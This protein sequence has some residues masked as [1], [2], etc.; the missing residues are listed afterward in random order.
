MVSQSS[1]LAK[2]MVLR[3]DCFGLA[4]QAEDEVGVDDEAEVVAVLD[5]VAGALDGGALLDVLEDLRVAGL[6]ADDEQAAAGSFMAL[7]VSR[8]VVTRE[9]QDQVRPSGFSFSQSSMVRALLDVEGVVVEEEFLDVGEE[10]LG[11]RH[12][13]GDV[14]GGALAPGV[15]GERLRPEAEGALRRAAAGA[16]ERDVRMQQERDVVAR[17]V[18]VAGVDVGDPGH[19]GLVELLDLRTVGVVDVGAVFAA[20]ADAEDLVRAACSWRTRRRRSR[21]RG[22][23]RSRWRSTR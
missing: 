10:L 19:V 11:V 5:E 22:G 16:V 23:R 2:S 3:I 21:T 18:H 9:V 17:D 4:G 6:E 14:V 7:S 13:G 15:A 12:L 20:V 1:V 8:S